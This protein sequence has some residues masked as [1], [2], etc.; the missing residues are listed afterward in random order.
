MDFVTDCFHQYDGFIYRRKKGMVLTDWFKE[1]IWTSSPTITAM[2]K[3][4]GKYALKQHLPLLSDAMNKQDQEPVTIFKV[5]QE[6]GQVLRGGVKDHFLSE[7]YVYDPPCLK[8]VFL[9]E[10]LIYL[11]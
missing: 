1:K 9:L 7:Q 2:L 3:C 6:Y 4:D 11:S 8:T 5:F 10:Y